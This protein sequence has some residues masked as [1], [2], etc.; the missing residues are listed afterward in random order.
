MKD[1]KKKIKELQ[2]IVDFKR[3]VLKLNLD[4]M[5]RSMYHDD[6]FTLKNYLLSST[7]ILSY[8]QVQLPIDS[9][10]NK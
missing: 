5:A 2:D 4:R 9:K 8:Y 7:S 6:L 1:T 3:K 10:D